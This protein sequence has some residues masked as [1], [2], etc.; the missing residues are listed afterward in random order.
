MTLN[1]AYPQDD[2]CR[3]GIEAEEASIHM[4]LPSYT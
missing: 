4:L 2:V 3:I 1:S